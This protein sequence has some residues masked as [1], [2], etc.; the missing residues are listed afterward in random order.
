MYTGQT[1]NQ[2][3]IMQGIES[4]VQK[5]LGLDGAAT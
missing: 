2:N 3:S 4:I 1:G 5:H